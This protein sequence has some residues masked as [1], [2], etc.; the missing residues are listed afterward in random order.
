M[1]LVQLLNY[2]RI[3]AQEIRHLPLNFRD[4]PTAAGEI[5]FLRIMTLDGPRH[6]RFN[7][8]SLALR[9][10][11]EPPVELKSAHEVRLRTWTRSELGE[12]LA[13][14]GF[15][16]R[17]VHGDMTGGAYEAG[18]SHDLV[19]VAALRATATGC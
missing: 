8:M 10:G 5:V 12:A 2:E 1:L 6:V 17:A 13:A 7:P 4:D 14:A 3:R 11:Q 9:P 16:V 15:A 19:V 18:R